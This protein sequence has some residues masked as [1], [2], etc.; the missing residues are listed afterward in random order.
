MI[1]GQMSAYWVA[2]RVFIMIDLGAP[3]GHPSSD[4]PPER[5]SD[6]FD[7]VDQEIDVGLGGGRVGDDHPEEVDSVA[8]RLV[9]HHRRPLQ[10]HLR[11]DLGGDLQDSDV[12]G[13]GLVPRKCQNSTLMGASSKL[14]SA[15]LCTLWSTWSTFLCT[16]LVHHSG[17]NLHLGSLYP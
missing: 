11:L 3:H 2:L 17:Q 12:G 1:C 8:E 5:L 13:S 16:I 7:L 10:H 4:L 15:T 9:A 14:L 6:S